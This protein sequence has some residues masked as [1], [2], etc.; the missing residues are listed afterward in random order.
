MKK[1]L[2]NFLKKKY[3]LMA[4][5]SV[6]LLQ[7]ISY[8][9]A[10]LPFASELDELMLWVKTIGWTITAILLIK[11]VISWRQGRDDMWGT[12]GWFFATAIVMGFGQEIGSRF[13]MSGALF[14]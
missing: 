7:K 8:S 4:F 13:G 3:S 11:F 5:L 1:K 9:T 12:F 14:L 2:Q 10:S 6:V